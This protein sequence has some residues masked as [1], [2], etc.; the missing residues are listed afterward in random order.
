MITEE[1]AILT[2]A[3]F[4]GREGSRFTMAGNGGTCELMLEAAEQFSR[5]CRPGGA[6]RL[7]FRGPRDP[8]YPQAI[9][10]LEAPGFAGEIFLVPIAQDAAGT[11]YEAIFN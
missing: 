11:L 5:S 7:A 2:W 4:A 10:G 6:F 9:Y 1:P 8:V 3:D